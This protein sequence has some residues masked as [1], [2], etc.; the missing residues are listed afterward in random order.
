[1]GSCCCSCSSRKRVSP[2]QHDETK[3]QMIEIRPKRILRI[4]HINPRQRDKLLEQEIQTYLQ[5]RNQGLTS[6]GPMSVPK[7]QSVNGNRQGENKTNSSQNPPGVPLIDYK[8]PDKLKEESLNSS[9]SSV[10]DRKALI[11]ASGIEV[12]MNATPVGPNESNGTVQNSSSIAANTKKTITSNPAPEKDNNAVLFFIHGVGGS[13]DI[14][15][16]QLDYFENLGYEIVA[17]DLIGHGLSCGPREAK[18]YHFDQ[19]CADLE[20]VFDRYCKRKNVVIGHSYGCSFAAMLARRRSRRVTKLIMI[21]GGGPTPL[22]PQPGVFALPVCMLACLRPCVECKYKKS[23]FSGKQPVIRPEEAFAVPTY[24]LSHTMNGQDWADGDELYHNWITCP[25]LLIYGE[26]DKL[27]TLQE[28]ENMKDALCDVE[29]EIIRDSSHM[30][31]IEDPQR[32]NDLIY[33]FLLRNTRLEGT[34]HLLNE[35]FERSKSRASIRSTKSAKSIPNL[36]L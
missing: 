2:A 12:G 19:M 29:L 20:E 14:W 22:A 16:A 17:P 34:S 23:A 9:F 11:S 10:D 32:V 5:Y 25:T 1:M 35:E 26:L 33:N 31:M 36:N 24:V 28:E 21:S 27:I 8:V 30:V 3:N 15:C 6:T 7:K 13:S 4:Q 18:H